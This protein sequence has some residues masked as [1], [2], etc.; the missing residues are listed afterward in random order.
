VLLWTGI[1][2]LSQMLSVK[3]NPRSNEWIQANYEEKYAGHGYPSLRTNAFTIGIYKN[4]TTQF[5]IY[6]EFYT[7]L[8]AIFERQ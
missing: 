8:R 5:I 4:K 1:D 6:Y 7:C 3:S 2:G